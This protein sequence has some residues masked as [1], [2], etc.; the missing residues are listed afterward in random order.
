MNSVQNTEQQLLIL[1]HQC[2][3]CAH[4]FFQLMYLLQFQSA[5]LIQEQ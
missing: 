2:C 1:Q 3:I 4:K 5:L